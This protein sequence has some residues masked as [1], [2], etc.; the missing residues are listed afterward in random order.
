V[1]RREFIALIA[2]V[3][4]SATAHAQQSRR[5]RRVGA[6]YFSSRGGVLKYHQAFLEEL[7]HLGWTEG[8]NIQLDVRFA[9][10]DSDRLGVFA[11]ELVGLWP[12]VV[13]ASSPLEAEVRHLTHTAKSRTEQS[14]S[15]PPRCG[16]RRVRFCRDQYPQPR[17]IS[18]ARERNVAFG[19]GEDEPGGSAT[20]ATPPDTADGIGL[21]L[22]PR[23][24]DLICGAP[25]RRHPGQGDTGMVATWRVDVVV[26]PSSRQSRRS[27][28]Y[29]TNSKAAP[30]GGPAVGLRD[31]LGIGGGRRR[32]RRSNTN[33]GHRANDRDAREER[34]IGRQPLL[35]ARAC[36]L[37]RWLRAH[38]VGLLQQGT[39]PLLPKFALPHTSS[40]LFLSFALTC[41][42]GLTLRVDL[43]HGRTNVSTHMFEHTSKDG[44]DNALNGRID[45][46]G[47]WGRRRG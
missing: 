21:L 29:S 17:P 45:H 18:R 24:Y 37:S 20:I 7:Q 27:E 4:W 46:D 3:A 25:P 8:R 5:M 30:K 32:C 40:S 10:G 35:E 34:T 26:F 1:R 16:E 14:T 22:M 38:R 28:G 31:H 12:E 6:L 43:L 41:S 39:H 11:T 9:A 47:R 42:L 19:I 15:D 13:V 33:G 23:A 44:L 2:G 36:L